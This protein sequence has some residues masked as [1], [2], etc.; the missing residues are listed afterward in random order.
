M[1]LF[2]IFRDGK[3]ID[4]IRHST[5][6]NAW[7]YSYDRLRQLLGLT[8]D[9]FNSKLVIFQ[10]RHDRVLARIQVSDSVFEIKV[11]KVLR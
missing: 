4:Q 2:G 10:G 1:M 6:R 3:C 5:Y 7:S 8:E 11:I 9:E